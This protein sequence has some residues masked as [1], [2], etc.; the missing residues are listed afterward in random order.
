MPVFLDADTTPLAQV[1]WNLLNNSAKYTQPGGRIAL[2]TALEGPDAVVTVEDTGIGIPADA[3]PSLFE[4]YS[5]VDGNLDH[6]QGGLGIGLALVKALTESHGGTVEA[7]SAGVGQ[8]SAFV[9]R[10]PMT[11]AGPLG[12]GHIRRDGAA[13]P[14]QRILIVEDNRDAASSLA[15]L[16]DFLGHDTR[17]AYDGIEGVEVAEAFRPDLIVLD[18]GLPKLNGF[19]VCRRIR[20]RPW[21]KDVVIAAATAWGCADDRRRSEEAGFDH[22]LVKP[23]NVTVLRDLASRRIRGTRPQSSETAQN[24]AVG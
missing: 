6:A 15:M 19:D 21:A 17:V 11:P 18:I 24:D 5:Q 14:R 12:D 13:G 20:K 4:L 9:V 16:L 23:V 3:L 1:F 7:Y 22:H 10:L 8:G 2:T